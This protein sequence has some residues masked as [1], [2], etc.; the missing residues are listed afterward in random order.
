MSE[1]SS[2]EKFNKFM[3]VSGKGSRRRNE[4]LKKIR[5]NWDLIKGFSRPK[6]HKQNKEEVNKIIDKL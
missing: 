3:N 5:D 1:L 4:D 2:G 6:L